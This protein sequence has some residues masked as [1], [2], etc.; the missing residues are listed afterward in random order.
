[1]TKV[2]KISRRILGKAPATG[3]VKLHSLPEMQ[4]R[5]RQAVDLQPA[6]TVKQ[7]LRHGVRPE[8]EV[9]VRMPRR[10][11]RALYPYCPIREV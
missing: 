4:P 3:T 1:M 8:R 10:L 2:S 9:V 11:F 7:H 5:Q 6:G